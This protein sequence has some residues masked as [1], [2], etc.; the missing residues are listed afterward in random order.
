MDTTRLRQWI[1]LAGLSV[2]LAGC[3]GE[4]FTGWPGFTEHFT[5]YP[6][7]QQPP[8]DIGR[9]LLMQYRPRIYKSTDQQG[10]IDFY[11]QYIANGTLE[12]QGKHITNNVT[13]ALLNQYAEDPAALFT[14]HGK[15]EINAPA[16]VYARVDNDTLSYQG[17]NFDL[18]FLTYN[19]VFPASGMINGMGLL[20]TVGLSIVGNLTDWHQLDH[21]VGLSVVLYQ[22]KPIAVM[23]QQHNYQTTYLVGT[24]LDWPADNRVAVDIAL[25]S[26]ELYLHKKEPTQ[27]PAVSFIT[28]KNIT[29]MMSGERKPLMAGFD[30]THGE[31]EVDYT[32]QYL[33]P[34]DAFYQF[35]GQLGKSRL[36]PG[37]DGP[38][39]A[40][41]V[42]LPGLMPR[43]TR[44]AAGYR[45]ESLKN[46]SEKISALFNEAS[47]T[48]NE[49]ALQH[50]IRDFVTNAQLSQ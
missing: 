43:A 44:L 30:T 23:L 12:V 18:V 38:P 3:A 35:K 1:V 47:F 41:Y 10:P 37:R 16:T 28:A 8:D 20:A 6:P 33:S 34:A 26:N 48:I 27:H 31:N 5:R 24:D 32:L 25:R 29:F 42:T 40:D 45:T 46:E 4:S 11:S 2:W 21:Y 9:S 49:T 39:G 14:Y 36:L 7:A 50:Y 17:E 22:K 13:P 19:L 15:P